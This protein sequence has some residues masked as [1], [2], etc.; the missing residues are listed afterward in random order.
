[1]DLTKLVMTIISLIL[2]PELF[3]VIIATVLYN[4]YMSSK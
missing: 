1:M 3:I 2:T 4:L